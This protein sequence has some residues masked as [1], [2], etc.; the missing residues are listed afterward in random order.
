MVR[1]DL[2]K[3]GPQPAEPGKPRNIRVALV[4]TAEMKKII[5]AAAQAKGETVSDWLLD[6]AK[7]KLAK[8]VASQ[9]RRTK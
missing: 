4:T 7:K 9:R 8:Q 6:A 3:R 5:E 2:G 1:R